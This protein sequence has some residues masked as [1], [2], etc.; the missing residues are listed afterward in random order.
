MIFTV[1]A[2]DQMVILTATVRDGQDTVTLNEALS[3][4]R[5]REHGAA[6]IFAADAVERAHTAVGAP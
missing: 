6:I 5:A 3:P 4:A 1:R 2:G